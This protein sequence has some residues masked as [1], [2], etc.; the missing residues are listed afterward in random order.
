MLPCWFI[1]T[2]GRCLSFLRTHLI[3]SKR[4][5]GEEKDLADL[6]ELEFWSDYLRLRLAESTNCIPSSCSRAATFAF[7]RLGVMRLR[8]QG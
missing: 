6:A 4:A 7:N 8:P 3:A 5:R 2:A 1:V